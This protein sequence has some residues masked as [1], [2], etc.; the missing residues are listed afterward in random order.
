MPRR[1]SDRFVLA[2]LAVL[3]VSSLG[4]KAA[5]GPPRDG[6]MDVS[7][8]RFEREVSDLLRGQSFAIEEQRFAHRSTLIIA[9]RGD[10]RLAVRDA[11]EGASAATAFA[12][13]AASVGT[14][15]YLYRGGSYD[16]PPA[17]AMRIGRIQTE[18]LDRLGMSPRAPMPVALAASRECGG[19]DFGL[20]DVRI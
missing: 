10:C 8:T 11:R 19:G 18:L 13:E 15:R 9:T 17:F 7:A 4:L 6:L 20:A 16:R 5:A 1:A 14:V 2:A 3:A 12:G